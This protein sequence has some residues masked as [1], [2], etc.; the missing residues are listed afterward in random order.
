MNVDAQYSLRYYELTTG[1][2]MNSSKKLMVS[3][4]GVTLSAVAVA[5]FPELRRIGTTWTNNAGFFRL[6]AL[7]LFCLVGVVA[8]LTCTVL[9][10]FTYP[11][12]VYKQLR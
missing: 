6:I 2:N 12:R 5:I 1:D 3:I 8:P 7:S 4:A 10:W 11:K 9:V